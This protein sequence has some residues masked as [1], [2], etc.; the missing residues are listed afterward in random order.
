[1]AR[2]ATTYRAVEVVMGAIQSAIVGKLPHHL[3]WEVSIGSNQNKRCQGL[4][5]KMH[6]I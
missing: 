2:I 1:M 4:G 6:E 3:P 5:F